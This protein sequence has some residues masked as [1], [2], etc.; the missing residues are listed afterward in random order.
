LLLS[1]AGVWKESPDPSLLL[2]S[3]SKELTSELLSS[4]LLRRFFLR[5]FDL[6]GVVNC[7]FLLGDPSL[8]DDDY[9]D[10]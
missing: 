1:L 9:I 8:S 3:L 6:V 7:T 10:K 2:D 4:L 5:F